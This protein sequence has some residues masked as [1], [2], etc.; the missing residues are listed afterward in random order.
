MHHRVIAQPFGTLAHLSR[1]NSKLGPPFIIDP[2]ALAYLIRNKIVSYT[3]ADKAKA[4]QQINELAESWNY[5]VYEDLKK[6]NYFIILASK[7]GGQYLIYDKDPDSE[8]AMGIV[9]TQPDLA[10]IEMNRISNSI[11]KTGLY[12]FKA[13]TKD[14]Q[15]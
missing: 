6:K 9:F 10:L 2:F 14:E 15:G 13:E 7:F 4:E 12:A 8:H 11:K 3:S 1:Q 5:K